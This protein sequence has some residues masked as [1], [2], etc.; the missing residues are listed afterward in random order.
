MKGPYL[1]DHTLVEPG[2]G[3]LAADESLPT[4][5]KRFDE[6]GVESTEITRQAFREIVFT[7]PDLEKYISGVI[8]FDETVFQ[9]AKDGLTLASVLEK[10]GIIPGIKVDEGKDSFEQN[11]PEMVTRGIDTLEKRLEKYTNQGL[12][13]TKWRAVFSIGNEMPSQAAIEINSGLLAQFAFISQEKGFIPIIEPEVLM[14]G[15]HTIEVCEE[16]TKKVLSKVFSE[17]E[18]KKVDLK[19]TLLKVNMIVA[20]KDN[21][22]KSNPVDVAKITLRVLERTVPPEIPGIVFLSGGISSIDATIYLN[23]INKQAN[24]LEQKPAWKLS[25]SFGRA[26]QKP[27]LLAWKGIK[28][29][30][31]MVQEALLKRARLNSLACL[32][33]YNPEMEGAMNER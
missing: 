11:S 15:G 1:R 10:K 8:L 21:P 20:G 6:I 22:Q 16:A 27:A 5:K 29:N 13:F 30:A 32:G 23:E 7:T 25:F 31:T 24:Q 19:V 2:K 9:K 28:E 18:K 14:N 12:K 26:L 3:I 4:I 33:Q 17:L